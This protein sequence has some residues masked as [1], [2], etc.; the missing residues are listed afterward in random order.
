MY[1]FAKSDRDN[2][3]QD[4]LLEFRR[5]AEDMLALSDAQIEARSKIGT[6]IEI[7]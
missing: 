5:T 2:I 3:R 7:L 1:G 4:E 6:I